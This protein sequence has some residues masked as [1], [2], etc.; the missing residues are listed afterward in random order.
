MERIV[1]R[2]AEIMRHGAADLARR[3]E[4]ARLD[5][6]ELGIVDRDRRDEVADAALLE[7]GE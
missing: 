6:H 1:V 4:A 2:P 5:R 3:R 7:L